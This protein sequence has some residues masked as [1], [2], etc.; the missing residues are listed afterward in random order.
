MSPLQNLDKIITKQDLLK[1][2]A[3]NKVPY[4]TLM[5]EDQNKITLTINL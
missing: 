2:N 3:R 4:F 5:Q 1:T